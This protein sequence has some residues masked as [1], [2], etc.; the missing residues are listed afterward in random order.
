VG[1]LLLVPLLPPYLSVSAPVP[2]SSLTQNNL[3]LFLFIGV[4]IVKLARSR[5]ACTTKSCQ[6]LPSVETHTRANA[7][8]KQ[9]RAWIE[10]CKL[11]W[12]RS[13][14]AIYIYCNMY[15]ILGEKSKN[16]MRGVRG[17]QEFTLHV[18]DK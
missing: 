13:T 11:Q 6:H 9:I 18:K 2:S 7:A 12:L 16:D 5:L 4:N 1:P 17:F 3:S 10:T 14:T 8:I 15:I